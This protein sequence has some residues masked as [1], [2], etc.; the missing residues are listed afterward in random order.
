MS[1]QQ[2]CRLYTKTILNIVQSM[3]QSDIEDP[4]PTT[5]LVFPIAHPLPGST[6]GIKR[7][8]G[9]LHFRSGDIHGGEHEMSLS[10]RRA[11]D[12]SLL[13]TAVFS[14][15][16]SSVDKLTGGFVGSERESNWE[17]DYYVLV[18]GD[19]LIV[20]LNAFGKLGTPIRIGAFMSIVYVIIGSGTG[21][22][23]E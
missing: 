4:T 11:S 9:R 12:V 21:E 23:K 18:P 10:L 8:Q 3:T 14:V 5:S 15:T 20:E 6:V 13:G 17:P 2:S 1:A 16:I 22:L 19:S 7:V